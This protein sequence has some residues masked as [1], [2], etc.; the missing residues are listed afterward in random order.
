MGTSA[1]INYS[2]TYV[3]LFKLK[4][5]MVDYKEFLLFY[6]GFVNNGIR[7]WKH[8]LPNSES[9]FKEFVPA[10]NNLAKLK[11]TCTGFVKTLKFLDL[12]I[13]IKHQKLHFKTFQK[14]QNLYLYIPPISAQSLNMVQGLIFSRLQCYYHHN[15]NIED[16]YTMA[17]LLTKRLGLGLN[18]PYIL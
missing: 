6:R 13:S 14:E 4:T 1:A 2:Y 18:S 3:G 7:V 17:L 8:S 15:T 12:T 5:L 10:L 11:W 9:K 16:Y